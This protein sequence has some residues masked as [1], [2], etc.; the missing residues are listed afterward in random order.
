MDAGTIVVANGDESVRTLI[1]AALED[2]GYCVL[3]PDPEDGLADAL[4]ERP[5]LILVDLDEPPAD[6]RVCAEI[7][8]LR[9]PVV[10]L[11]DAPEPK[12]L[13]VDG[14]L[15]KP[16]DIDELYALARRWAPLPGRPV[17]RGH[18]SR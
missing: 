17:E 12:D 3:L 9:I 16:F 5:A 15:A 1:Q 14:W 11:S 4:R 18:R 6:V 7:A 2:Q 13:D 10:A 8:A